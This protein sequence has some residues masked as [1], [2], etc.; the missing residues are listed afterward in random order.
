MTAYEGLSNLGIRIKILTEKAIARH[1]AD[2]LAAVVAAK[3]GIIHPETVQTLSEYVKQ[4]GLLFTIEPCFTHDNHG[5]KRPQLSES[6]D[7]IAHS[8]R[9][10]RFYT[11]LTARAIR[12]IVG[13]RLKEI[14][15][16]TPLNLTNAYGDSLWGVLWLVADETDSFIVNIV[17]TRRE[18]QSIRLPLRKGA[19][20]KDLISGQELKSPIKLSPLQPLLFEIAKTDIIKAI[21]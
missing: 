8:G 16:G 19:K 11:P 2:G 18:S 10:L 5:L 15:R 14:E 13:E 7:S 17:N 21:N 9:L 12:D 4:G 20:A 3:A 1:E 6:L